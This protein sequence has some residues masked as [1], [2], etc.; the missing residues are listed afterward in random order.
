MDVFR[1]SLLG[2]DGGD[3]HELCASGRALPAGSQRWLFT[4]LRH[5]S[6]FSK[7]WFF[8]GCEGGCF[9]LVVEG[10]AVGV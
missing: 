5:D 9:F 3:G 4:H 7:P 1:L 8:M 2:L 6:E 10:D